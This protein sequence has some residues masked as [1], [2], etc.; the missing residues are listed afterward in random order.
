MPSAASSTSEQPDPPVIF[1]DRNLGKHVVPG[2]LRL[3]PG[4]RVEIHDDHFAPDAP[5]HEILSAVGAH[6]WLFVTKDRNI[7]YSGL[8]QVAI[9]QSK[10]C[11]FFIAARGDLSGAELAEILVKA[12]PRVLRFASRHA[13]P[14]MA[15]ITRQG[16]VEGPIGS[17]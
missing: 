11:C 12:L 5:D 8:A 16:K 15:N 2:V 14:F 3:Q 7:R 4:I 6:G 1:L 13:P 10:A 17:T 9:R